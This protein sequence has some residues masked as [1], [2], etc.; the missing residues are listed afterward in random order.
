[1]NEL[2]D[3]LN[4]TYLYSTTATSLLVQIVTNQ[5]DTKKLAEEELQKRG[6]NTDGAWIGFKK[7]KR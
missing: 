2:P 7:K 3:E 6:L 1:M 5:I 4:P